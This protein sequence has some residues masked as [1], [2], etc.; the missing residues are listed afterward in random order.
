M[1]WPNWR[2]PEQNR[3]SRETGLIDHWDPETKENV[4]WT[5][6]DGGQHL[7]ADRDAWQGVLDRSLQA[8]NAR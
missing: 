4:L 2:G 6:P 8:G 5:N 1:D 3:V 7:V